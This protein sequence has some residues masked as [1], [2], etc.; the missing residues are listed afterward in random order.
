MNATAS[1][2]ASGNTRLADF[3]P[4][5]STAGFR[6]S[7]HAGEDLPRA[8]V[9]PPVKLIFCTSGMADERLAG[10]GGAGQHVD[11]ARRDARPRGR[12]P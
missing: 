2:S 12:G 1:R 7:A 5:S 8:V 6:L 9:G 3:P 4:S 11:H 10:L